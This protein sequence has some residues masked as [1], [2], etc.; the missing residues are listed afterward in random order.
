MQL[1]RILLFLL[2]SFVVV[3]ACGKKE[4]APVK[5]AT[6]Q[7]KPLPQLSQERVD[8][9]L[10][11]VHELKDY[12]RRFSLDDEKIVDKRDLMFLAHGSERTWFA[13]EKLFDDAGMSTKEFWNIK[14]KLEDAQKFLALKEKE[15]DDNKRLDEL[16]KAG[17]EELEGLKAELASESADVDQDGLKK[18]IA[19][20]ESQIEEFEMLKGNV[21]LADV[22][23]NQQIID[24]WE[25]NHLKFT[26]ALEA[27]WKGGK[28]AASEAIQFNSP[29]S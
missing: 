21:S 29:H 20:I 13:Y 16:I 17:R 19:D 23:L 5:S 14:K 22:S 10:G 9:W 1:P 12:I 8:L 27:M 6:K 24:L 28:A 18:I 25:K 3:T 4:E 11:I 2:L 15:L 7:E 26:S